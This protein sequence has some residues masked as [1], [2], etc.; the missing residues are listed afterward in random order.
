MNWVNG[1]TIHPL[2]KERLARRE[3][4]RRGEDIRR[5]RPGQGLGALLPLEQL[6]SDVALCPPVHRWP[7]VTLDNILKLMPRQRIVRLA[8]LALSLV[9]ALV[10]AEVGLR[11]WFRAHGGAGDFHAAL[12]RARGAPTRGAFT[13][14]E[15]VQASAVPDIVYELRPG[16]EGTFRGQTVRTNSN[17]LRGA[18]DFTPEKPAGT[19]RIAVLGDSNT[20]GWGVGEGEPYVQIVQRQLDTVAR[21]RRFEVLNFG[22]PGYNT[23]MEVATYEHKAAPFAPDLVVIHFIGND[24]DLPHFMQPP[25]S[26]H[27]AVHSYLWDLLRARF[28]SMQDEADPDLLSHDRS[29]LDPEYRQK[30]RGQYQH[31]VG[32]DAYRRE[33][34]RLGALT[35]A[36]KIPVIV[37]ALGDVSGEGSL[38]HQAAG[39]NGFRF[40]DASPRFYRYLEEHNLGTEKADWQHTFRI[41][42]DGHPNRLGHQLYAEVLMDE[43]KAM[44]V[45]RR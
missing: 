18:R 30:V 34:A 5:R 14:I 3:E 39:A 23:T 15:L 33:M 7:R 10:L 16:L 44:G 9:L 36:R 22:V 35:R 11:L 29:K 26:L 27:T 13:L 43:L 28:G 24:L 41:P 31:M 8:L 25:E 37:M 20:F 38:A 12:L 17:G 21:D 4:G 19:F 42:H 32:P 6:R 40:L 45:V 2:L 1:F